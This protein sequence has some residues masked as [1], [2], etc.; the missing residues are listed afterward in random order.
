[1]HAVSQPSTIKLSVCITTLNRAAFIGATLESILVQAT[2]ECEVVVLD[3]GSTDDTERVVS[4]Y[5]RRFDQL[6]YIK[7]NMNNGF[8]RDCD[9]MVELARG[10]YCWLMT[11]D[12][13]LKEGALVTIL[14]ALGRDLSF[15]I[16]NVELRDLNMSKV[17]QRRWLN[18]D[19]DRVY[20]PEE[21]DSLVL[22]TGNILKFMGCMVIKR[23]LWLARQT[24]RYYGSLFNY[25]GVIFHEPFPSEALVIAEPF[26]SYRMGNSHAWSPKVFETFMINLPSLVWSLAL[27]EAAKRKVCGSAEPWRDVQELLL[28]RGWGFYS[29]AEYRRCLRPR[30]RSLR[31]SFT[32]MFVAL[33]PGVVV[34]AF[35]VFYHLMS[36]RPYQ[37]VWEPAGLM[38]CLR[39]SP[40]YF[41]NWQVFTRE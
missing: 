3:G 19:S 25:L 18:F 1:M 29:L 4:E 12:D 40:F 11:D 20:G 10:E 7:Q 33:L 24:K 32:P 28:Q 38:Q 6:R 35:L 36:S 16:V 26:I 15:V 5:T 27:S 9:R 37:G 21:M 17:L 23:S 13:L 31:E 39:D 22:E 34:N 30:L 14:Q 2:N 41:R 8:D